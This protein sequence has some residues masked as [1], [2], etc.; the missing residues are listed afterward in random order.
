[1]DVIFILSK[2]T[3]L[4]SHFEILI[5]I[6]KK[7][8][9]W[10]YDFVLK[11]VSDKD[12]LKYKTLFNVKDNKSLVIKLIEY[13]MEKDEVTYFNIYSL[14]KMIKK[15]KNSNQKYGIYRIIKDFKSF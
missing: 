5:V 12:M 9:N 2:Y 15:Y 1:M 8:P 3:N 6:F 11:N 4:L 10:Y 13:A 14:N 7:S